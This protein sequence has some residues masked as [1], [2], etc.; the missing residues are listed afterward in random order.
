VRYFRLISANVSFVSATFSGGIRT[1]RRK[2]RAIPHDT[3]R[4]PKSLSSSAAL[5]E[6]SILPLQ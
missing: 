4:S 1:Q 5:A 6:M 2:L 3:S